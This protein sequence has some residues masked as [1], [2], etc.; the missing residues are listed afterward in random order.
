VNREHLKA[1]LWL[2]WR[3]RVN[4][5][6]KAGAVNAV[7]FGIFAVVCLIA[8]VMLFVVGIMVGLFA[9]R[10][11]PA[12]AHMFAWDGIVAAFLF[13]WMIG[14]VAELQRSEALALDRFLH[15][16]VSLSGAFLI[17]YLSSLFSLSMIVFVPGAIGLILGLTISRGPLMLLELPLLAAALFALTAVTYQFQGWLASL[18]ANPRRRRTIIVLV[19]ASFILI[20]QA[21]NLI[22]VVRPWE[23]LGDANARRNERVTELIK[24]GGTGKMTPPNTPGG[25][26]RSTSSSRKNRRRPATRPSTAPCGR[27]TCSTPCCRP[28]GYRWGPRAWPTAPCCRR[29][30]GRSA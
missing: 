7:L 6:R 25:C 1:F 17:N 26:R 4:Q 28:A 13:S 5:F 27:P 2:R 29:Y 22:N 8:S 14:L 18:M 11:A 19:T 12:Y 30:W 15:L 21:P 10:N 3:L 20:A 16:P 24:E 9:F 23:R